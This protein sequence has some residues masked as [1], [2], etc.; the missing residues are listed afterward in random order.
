MKSSCGSSMRP[1]YLPRHAGL[2]RIG[3]EIVDVVEHQ[4]QHARIGEGVIV[5]AENAAKGFAAVLAV[6]R[7]EIEI[8]IAADDPPR[9]PERTE[10]R[11]QAR[12]D[13][14]I[15][16][17]DVAAIDREA[18]LRV[19]Q[20][21]DQILADEIDLGFVLRLRVGEQHRLERFRL[22]LRFQRKIER[23]RQRPGRRKPSNCRFS[24]AGEPFGR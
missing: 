10:D 14:Q 22:L 7:F 3:P 16:E 21:F 20:R 5:R 18:R 9:K 4:E 23:R 17:G 15:V 8:V 2:R 13:G 12:I 1:T 11:V 19:L 24:E 6:R